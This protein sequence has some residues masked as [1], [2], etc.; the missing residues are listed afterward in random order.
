MIYRGETREQLLENGL[1]PG[2]ADE[3]LAFNGFLDAAGRAPGEAIEP[4]KL[5][6]VWHAYALGQI[7]GRQA[8]EQLAALGDHEVDALLL[9]LRADDV[10][11]GAVA[12]R[13]CGC[14]DSYGCPGGCSWA[15]S[16]L[17]TSCVAAGVPA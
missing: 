13:V 16:D 14:T 9:E 12:C 10:L 2:D 4:V 15:E 1:S 11:N 7:N 17:C 3:M 6:P 5:G 8:L